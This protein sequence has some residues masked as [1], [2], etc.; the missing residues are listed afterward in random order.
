[1]KRFFNHISERYYK[2]KLKSQSGLWREILDYQNKTKSTGAKYATLYQ[3]YNGVLKRKPKGIVECGT[4]LS[5]VVMCKAIE[6]LKSIDP[7]YSP[8]FVSLESEEFYWRHAMDLLPEKYKPFVEIRH[9]E[10]IE[11][12]YSMFRGVRY[13]DIPA[14]PYDFVFV[15]GPDYKTDQGG[16]SFCFDLIKYIENSET[17]VYAVIDTRVSTVYVLQK[18]LGKKLVSYNGISRVGLVY[19]ARKSDL[20]SL[21][22][23]PSAHFVQNLTDRTLDLKFKKVA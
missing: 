2:S 16:P 11:D 12:A 14:G 15:D 8:S 13:K 22:E 6:E 7:S 10:L 21:T 19:G 9:S 20:L 5:T 17:P 1:M 18:I 4:G 23:P 3:I